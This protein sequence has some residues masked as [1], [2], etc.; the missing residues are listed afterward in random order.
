MRS[1]FQR[2]QSQLTRLHCCDPVRIKG[3]GIVHGTARPR[4]DGRKEAEQQG[5]SAATAASAASA[6]DRTAAF[7]PNKPHRIR[8]NVAPPHTLHRRLNKKPHYPVAA[9]MTSTTDSTAHIM[10]C[11]RYLRELDPE[12][13]SFRYA[14]D[15]T[16]YPQRLTA[17][18]VAMLNIMDAL[19]EKQDWHR[20]IQ[21]PDIVS[22]WQTE[23]L[24]QSP[25]MSQK[26]FDWCIFELK[27]KAEWLQ[28]TG[29]IRTLDTHNRCIKSD[30]LLTPDFLDS[31]KNATRPLLEQEPKDWHPRSND[32]VLDL[33]HPSLYPLVYGK[34]HYLA[35]GSVNLDAWHQATQGTPFPE[36]AKP[37]PERRGFRAFATDPTTLYS[38]RF[39][40][41]PCDVAFEGEIGTNVSIRS[42]INNLEPTANS[43]LYTLIE[44]AISLSIEPWN[45]VLVYGS[46]GRTPLRI[47]CTQVEWEPEDQPE[48]LSEPEWDT[49]DDDLDPDTR[50]KIDEL[51]A[52]PDDPELVKYM[53]PFDLD[54]A[55]AKTDD[56]LLWI[57]REKFNHTRRIVHP[58]PGDEDAYQEWRDR[59]SGTYNALL[60][61][62]MAYSQ[63]CYELHLEQSY[64]DRGLQV[65]VKLASIE[66]TPDKPQYAG[67]NWHVEGMMNE[68]IVATSI[69]Y[70]DV[71]NV[72]TARISFRQ[73]ANLDDE[74]ME[75]EQDDHGPFCVVFGTDSLRDEAKLQQLGSVATPNGRLLAFPNTLQHRVEPFEL[76]DK[77][78]SGHRRFLVLW[79]VDPN[80]HLPSTSIVPPQQQG[81]WSTKL[82]SDASLQGRGLITLDEAKA[83]RLELMDER[84]KGEQATAGATEEYNFCEH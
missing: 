82:G 40:W 52:T 6:K 15:P 39:Q 34:T 49:T 37:P 36:Q 51:L 58:E 27:D 53:G 29:M 5:Y 67:G 45:Q 46:K 31:L 26:A 56:S 24:E 32:Q 54:E 83:L 25:I 3:N 14:V 12:E 23:A 62:D 38:D 48:W 81:W 50:V 28:R 84:T 18:E 66:L 69:L 78:K 16:W 55:M 33:V 80:Y 76:I 59:L 19:T 9:A 72:T 8:S 65:I 43:V 13:S 2:R 22:K 57:A 64:R 35:Q 30:T 60:D 4:I 77:N 44:Q 11:G 75:Y 68:H 42:Y 20:K 63:D 73:N 71:E 61:P 10:G 47:E 21:D 79:L 41:L 74:E 70:Y 7:G 1:H 17:R